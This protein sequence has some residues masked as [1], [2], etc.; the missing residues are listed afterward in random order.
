MIWS[1]VANLIFFVNSIVWAGN[2]IDWSPTYCDICK[3]PF[4]SSTG[5]ATELVAQRLTF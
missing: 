3:P 2:T 4:L 5:L 1:A